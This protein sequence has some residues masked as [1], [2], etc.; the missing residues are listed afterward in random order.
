MP[1]DRRTLGASLAALLLTAGAS[2]AQPAQRQ[3]D[4]IIEQ[5]RQRRAMVAVN[6]A[7]AAA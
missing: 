2:H 3:Q 6:A 5:M 1:L 7:R 4:Q